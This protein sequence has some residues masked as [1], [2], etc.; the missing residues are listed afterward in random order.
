MKINFDS[1][2]DPHFSSKKLPTQ[3]EIENFFNLIDFTPELPDRSFFRR[4]PSHNYDAG[5]DRYYSRSHRFPVL[6]DYNDAN[7]QE[8][9][10]CDLPD[11]EQ[12][13]SLSND[14]LVLSEKYNKDPT[15]NRKIPSLGMTLPTDTIWAIQNATDKKC[16][17]YSSQIKSCKDM[18]NYKMNLNAF[19]KTFL[20]HEI[21]E[22]KRGLKVGNYIQTLT[23]TDITAK[24]CKL[25]EAYP[26]EPIYI[27]ADLPLLNYLYVHC[28][29][30]KG[31]LMTNVWLIQDSNDRYNSSSD[32]G[33]YKSAVFV[34]T[35]MRGSHEFELYWNAQRGHR[36]W[37]V[38][39]A[40]IGK[41]GIEIPPDPCE[42]GKEIKPI[43]NSHPRWGTLF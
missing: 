6:G 43:H 15:G 36:N 29:I 12:D 13:L 5:T 10:V 22:F 3:E 28:L 1:W 40:A 11:I 20:D 32:F 4:V 30:A 33:D 2:H 19:I 14:S 37:S 24:A 25:R 26:L 21:A 17:V 18:S 16:K 41:L 38:F 23:H 42:L 39:F 27:M 8:W 7:G 9:V 35:E 31:Q 34:T